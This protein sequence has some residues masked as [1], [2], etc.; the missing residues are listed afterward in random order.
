MVINSLTNICTQSF[1]RNHLQVQNCSWNQKKHLKISEKKIR[2]EKI[3]QNGSD[4]LKPSEIDLIFTCQHLL[5][6]QTE[7]NIYIC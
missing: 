1:Q 5:T 6:L 3:A 7:N 2:K 4:F